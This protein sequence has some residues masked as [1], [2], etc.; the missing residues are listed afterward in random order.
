MTSHS[1][2][3]R[4]ELARNL[5]EWTV[6]LAGLYGILFVLVG[7]NP[8]PLLEQHAS[9]LVAAYEPSTPA[10]RATLASLRGEFSGVSTRPPAMPHPEQAISNGIANMLAGAASPPVP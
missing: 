3:R 5:C 4:G 7:R 1:P 9:T 6:L 2:T 8:L 10:G